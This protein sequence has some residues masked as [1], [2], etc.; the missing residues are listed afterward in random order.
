MNTHLNLFKTYTKE[1]KEKQL[2]N[3]LTRALAI[4]LLENNMFL[5]G[6]LKTIL[7]EAVYNNIFSNF[8]GKSNLKIDIQKR[9][10]E[11]EGFDK[12]Y[13]VSVSGF[14]MN[15]DS[16]YKQNYTDEY[17]PITD[18]VISVDNVVIVFEV[19]R[20]NTNCTAQLYN[21]A[22]NTLK[23]S[24][25]DAVVDR[26]SV[27][28]VDLCWS[29]IA[30]LSLKIN[31]FQK[32]T[33]NSSRFLNDFIA[34]IRNHNYRWFPELPLASIKLNKKP[35][36]VEDR[37]KTAI[38][39]SKYEGLSS[40]IGFKINIGWASEVVFRV[41]TRV[42]TVD[43]FIYPG[44]TK[45]QGYSL[46]KGK[47]EPKFK[48]KLTI[49]K[50]TYNVIKSFHI[51]F[52]SFQKYFQGLEGENSDMLLPM[53]TDVNFRN[54]SGR[55]KRGA[56][57]WKTVED[58]FDTHLKQDYNWKGRCRWQEDVLDSGKSQFDLSL[59]YMLKIKIPFEVLKDIDTA[60]N[61]LEPLIFFLESIKEEFENVLVI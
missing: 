59:G 23:T 15:T 48:E 41:D 50:N 11:L 17:V 13:A 27:T 55:K 61:N 1:N 32:S 2:E 33:N 12:I 29:K 22:L 30:E 57:N 52:T 56:K 53:I 46:F 10:N 18:M 26:N 5:H 19:K 54:F 39:N 49:Q 4:C 38:S 8:E 45:G 44:N 47:G 51:K 3:D 36:L 31:N 58:F 43:A 34:F 25:K 37:I 40:R 6:L 20:D 42:N 16:F 24:D 21:Q 60:D 7:K 28:A 9:V 14:K 35:T